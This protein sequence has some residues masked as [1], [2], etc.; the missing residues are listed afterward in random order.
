MSRDV[1]LFLEDIVESA[2]LAIEYVGS[3][4]KAEFLSLR[5][6]QD[7]VV[8]RLEIIGEA[9]K[10]VPE[11]VRLRYPAIPWAQVAGLRDVLTHG[12]FRVDLNLVW[13][14]VQR[15]LPEL[16]KRVSAILAE[17]A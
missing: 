8:R 11:D 17:L 4:S 10:N 2:R 1:R 15:D 3:M 6:I 13:T 7:A 5:P 16:E 14:V 12:Y 9:V